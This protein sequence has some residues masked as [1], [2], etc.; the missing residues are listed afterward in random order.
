MYSKPVSVI[1]PGY[2]GGEEFGMGF[3]NQGLSVTF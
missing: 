1:G 2:E 3:K